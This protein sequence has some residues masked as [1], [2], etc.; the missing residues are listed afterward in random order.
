[1]ELAPIATRPLLRQTIS[2]TRTSLSVKS[3]V[4]TSRG[5]SQVRV[6]RIVV[7][8]VVRTRITRTN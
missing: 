3:A 1:M 5:V 8:R 4:A 6:T 2:V 7:V